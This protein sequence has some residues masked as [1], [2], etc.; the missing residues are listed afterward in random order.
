MS[1]SQRDCVC[2]KIVN[3]FAVVELYRYDKM[4]RSVENFALLQVSNS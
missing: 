3:V 1:L 2:D 4:R